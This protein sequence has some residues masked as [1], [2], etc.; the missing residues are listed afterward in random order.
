MRPL[1]LSLM[2]ACLS[3]GLSACLCFPSK[4]TLDRGE[5][6]GAPVH[7]MTIDQVPV[8]GHMVE[9]KV[10]KSKWG[11]KEICGELLAVSRRHIWVLSEGQTR[12]IP[13]SRIRKLQIVDMFDTE[14]GGMGVWT[15]LGTISAVSHGF[16]GIISGPLWLVTGLSATGSAAASND[17]TVDLDHL[18]ALYQ[19][20]RFP[21]GMPR[22][23]SPAPVPAPA[24]A[25]EVV[26]VPERVEPPPAPKPEPP[27][28]PE[29][30]VPDDAPKMSGGF[31]MEGVRML[32]G[33]GIASDMKDQ[34]LAR[35]LADAR[36]R[37]QIAVLIQRHL[38]LDSPMDLVLQHLEIA[39]RW[40]VPQENAHYSIAVVELEK[41]GLTPDM[42]EKI[43]ESLKEE[44]LDEF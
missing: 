31:V 41:I 22:K 35:K 7:N 37:K 10:G 16:F 1:L 20:A 23:P 36:A 8:Y 11:S 42:A 19:Y 17:I 5:H 18:N 27:P 14:A 34:V 24:P 2:L 12:K 4:A 39:D 13:H 44:G 30:E 6:Q 25:P 29:P 43:W 21:Q 33:M 38:R 28:E 40:Q 3:H 9:V 32:W 15:A 26:T